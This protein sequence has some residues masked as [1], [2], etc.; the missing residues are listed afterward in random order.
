MLL[1]SMSFRDPV[2]GMDS[3]D[4]FAAYLWRIAIKGKA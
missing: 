4:V 1:E 3:T 2:H